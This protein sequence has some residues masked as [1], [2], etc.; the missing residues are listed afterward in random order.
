MVVAGVSGR[1]GRLESDDDPRGFSCAQEHV[2][3]GDAEHERSAE[4]RTADEFDVGAGGEAEVEE[5]AADDLVR[6]AAVSDDA[7]ALADGE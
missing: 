5:A 2:G 6:L 1:R 3:A 4:G 7:A